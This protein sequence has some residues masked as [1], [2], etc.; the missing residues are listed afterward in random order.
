MS[1]NIW[2]IVFEDGSIADPRPE[3]LFASTSK[4][5]IIEKLRETKELQNPEFIFSYEE[6][7]H[8][9]LDDDSVWYIEKVDEVI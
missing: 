8:L 2:V 3:V 9:I 6:D 5:K 7:D 4:A 1:K